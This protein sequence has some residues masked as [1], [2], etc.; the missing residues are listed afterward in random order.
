MIGK[1]IADGTGFTKL[2]GGT[3]NAETVHI[4]TEV[5]NKQL[6]K[7]KEDILKCN[8]TVE[9]DTVVKDQG[10]DKI[11]GL[12][13]YLKELYSTGNLKN[14]NINDVNKFA[15]NQRYNDIA[16]QAN[17]FKGVNAAIKEYN[18]LTDTA[19]KSKLAETINTTNTSLGKYLSN[20][21]GAEG[22]IF[23]Y[24]G[25]L[26]TATAKTIALEA[27]TMA[28]NAAI[29]MGVSLIVTGLFTAIDNLIHREERLAESAET[30]SNNIKTSKDSFDELKKTTGEITEEFAKLSQ[31][32]DQVTGKNK[33]LSSEEYERFLELSNQLAESLPN[34]GY[35]IDENGKK[36]VSLRGNV[37]E[38]TDSINNLVK[39]EQLLTNQEIDKNMDDVFKKAFED[40]QTYSG[41]LDYLN[42]VSSE[43][44]TNTKDSINKLLSGDSLKLDLSDNT[45]LKLL[46]DLKEL[47]GDVDFKLNTDAGKI[48]LDENSINWV[49]T[50]TN[51]EIAQLEAGA[52]R[53]TKKYSEIYNSVAEDAKSVKENIQT[54]LNGLSQYLNAWV[55][56]SLGYQSITETYGN[57]LGTAIQS[58]IDSIN[59]ANIDGVDNWDDAEIWIENN[60]LN[61]LKNADKQ[62]LRDAYLGLFSL[63][64][65][66]MSVNEAKKTIDGYINTLYSYLK[67]DNESHE[68]FK[69]R[70]GFDDSETDSLINNVKNKLQEKFNDKVSTLT[71]SDLK[72]AA[73]QIDVP[74]GTLLS[75]DEL[76]A[77]I[78]KVKESAS[79]TNPLLSFNEAWEDLAEETKE[80]LLELAKSGE[81]TKKTFKETDGTT[82]FLK[83]IGLSANEARAKVQN[84]LTTQ[85]KLSA[86]SQGSSSLTT[87]YDEF[88]NNNFVSSEALNGMS[89]AF[90]S[91]KGFDLFSQIVGDPT[92]GKKKIEDAFDD[93]ITE[94]LKDQQILV[95]TTE[96]N[97]NTVIANLKKDG[98]TNAEEVVN[99]YLKSAEEITPLIEGASDEILNYLAKNDETDVNNFITA[100][101]DKNANYGELVTALGEDNAALITKFGDQYGD[102]LANWISLLQSKRDEYNKFVEEYNASV[103][104]RQSYI[105]GLETSAE[106]AVATG[107]ASVDTL[108]KNQKTVNSA[109]KSMDNA[110]KDLENTEEQIK[111]DFLA[112]LGTI[113]SNFTKSNYSPTKSSSTKNSSSSKNKSTQIID[114]ISRRLDILQAKIDLTKTKFEN[115]F[116]L[117]AKK[118]NLNTQI[119]QTNTL[120]SAT[121]K[122]A[123]KYQKKANRVSL[124]SSLKKKVRNGDVTGS[125]S[126]LIA[127]YGEKKAE[128]I[129][130]YQD[131]YDKY[132]EEKKA[133]QE[134]TASIRELKEEKYQL[135]VDQADAKVS[136]LDAQEANATTATSKNKYEQ[137]KLKWIKQSYNYQIKIAKLEKDSAKVAQLKAEKV[138]A[139]AEAYK[140]QF[141]NIKTEYDNKIGLNNSQIANTQAQISALEAQGR[142]IATS[143]YEGMINTTANNRAKL[144]EEK[145][146]L[147]A[148][149]KNLTPYSDDWYEAK[150]DIDSVTQAI[151]ECDQT[152]AEFQKTINELDLK[153]FELIA[154]QLES[155]SNHIQF[156]T[157]ILSHK[158]LT[159]KEAG[160]ITK[161]GIASLSLY[162]DQIKNNEKEIQNIQDEWAKFTEQISKGNSGLSE[163]DVQAKYEEYS[164]N[165]RSL[166][167]ENEDLKDSIKSLVEDALNVQLDALNDLI[168]KR[169]EALQTAKDLYEYE[170]SIADQTKTITNI[171]K[172]IGALTGDSSEETRSKLQQLNVEL[173]SAQQDLKDTEYDKWISDQEDMLDDLAEEF[174]DFIE[175]VLN[176]TNSILEAVA[177]LIDEYGTQITETIKELGYGNA[178]VVGTTYYKDGSYDTTVTNYDGGTTT[179]S[180]DK[181][182]NLTNVVSSDSNGVT[183]YNAA[184]IREQ[185]EADAQKK[186]QA[187]A[188]AKKKAET[189]KKK[190]E[191]IIKQ[192]Y[193][194]EIQAIINN[195]AE[196]GNSS[197]NSVSGYIRTKLG[198]GID[199]NGIAELATFFNLK[200]TNHAGILKKLQAAGFSQGGVIDGNSYNGDKLF[201]RVNSGESV[202]TKKFTDLLPDT[203]D[204]MSKFINIKPYESLHYINSTP[205]QQTVNIENVTY[206]IEGSNV[207]DVDSFIDVLKHSSKVQNAVK[208][209]VA[210]DFAKSYSNSF[211]KI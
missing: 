104:T 127:T 172:Q 207:K 29:S 4:T 204:I 112:K 57:E 14:L 190:Q 81:L 83:Q 90:K 19:S 131:Y 113:N 64:T 30:A 1:I 123:T 41:E 27:A 63:D 166:I 179:Y 15:I 202:L 168:D 109:K 55:T 148:S 132:K 160:G 5:N 126:S 48:S 183:T 12:S 52:D 174:E 58:S 3:I 86:F 33:E 80:S 181:N 149:L 180:Y 146:K 200:P 187:E 121:K 167:S 205:N 69:I 39:S 43:I 59:W 195:H 31:G 50:L 79:T 129:T 96:K 125:L 102:D 56:T 178:N 88:K 142:R 189:E 175:N 47:F 143:Y 78:N 194:A 2:L 206:L 44:M 28:M 91:L 75:W 177:V 11:E 122:A 32:V 26:V 186:A 152:T 118:N 110:A 136:A 198:Y 184:K 34:V 23:S 20:L 108:T 196:L 164:A 77:K 170:R 161:E 191:E 199:D 192:D 60:I 134:L 93:I 107:D 151:Y 100:L 147:E 97:K 95:G 176:D 144:V 120:L 150:Q 85:E 7:L 37:D 201:A 71:Q 18:A 140:A 165:I 40:L 211:G 173:E 162:F 208:T 171:Q 92:S 45:N 73:E 138:T 66:D 87:A 17:G 133:V 24:A 98:I 82:D 21:K 145:A 157:D 99:S 130:K 94:Y 128:K 159:S 115:L 65:A 10:L 62:E 197:F 188:D 119:S 6:T 16:N 111:N 182:G 61:P 106:H 210:N 46:D 139:I 114:W 141:D 203:V 84:L 117:K 76:I 103:D 51:E 105:D 54:T 74:E 36:I 101:Q 89:D 25:S 135:Y 13:A 185:A 155:V 124:S 209:V 70:M 35:T 49:D 153:K 116:S 72:I 156:L 193:L 158:D 68:D 38:I 42:Q 154:S 22:N 8:T 137:S 67:E 163:E 53:I 169:K 9:I